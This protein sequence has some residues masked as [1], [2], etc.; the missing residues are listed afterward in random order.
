MQLWRWIRHHDSGALGPGGAGVCSARCG[1]RN[2]PL[3]EPPRGWHDVYALR[4]KRC[5][6]VPR[7][8][9]DD[10]EAVRAG[11]PRM[12]ESADR[13][14]VPRTAQQGKPAYD[15]TGMLRARFN[16]AYITWPFPLL[17]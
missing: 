13:S 5:R 2:P 14:L 4:G 3:S 16:K 15:R 9:G 11:L 10:H 7:D 17:M 1:N 6:R 12:E 8:G